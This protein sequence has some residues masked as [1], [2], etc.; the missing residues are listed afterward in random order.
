MYFDFRY[1]RYL[2]IITMVVKLNY[3]PYNIGVLY[4]YE[5]IVLKRIEGIFIT[6]IIILY[7]AVELKDYLLFY[8]RNV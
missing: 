3:E 7:S 6:I 4:K 5:N 1:N 8:Q 2:I